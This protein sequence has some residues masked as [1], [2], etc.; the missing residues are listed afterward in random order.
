MIGKTL[1]HYE[2]TELL[3][4]G[5][6]GAVYRARD[7]KLHREVAIK[8]LPPTVADDPERVAR[9]R[10]EARTLASLSDPHVAALYGMEEA[11]E[12]RFLVMELVEGEDLAQRLKRGK[13]SRDETLD[14]AIQIARGVEAAHARGIVHRDL[15][16]ANVMLDEDRRVK[17]LDFG[18]AR[19]V[20]DDPE[21]SVDEHSPTITADLTRAGTLL[22]TA[23]YMS[24]EQA[25]GRAVDHRSDIWAFGVMLYEMLSGERLFHGESVSDTLASVLKVEPEWDAL[26][27]DLP[28]SISRLLRRCLNKD[29]RERLQAIGDARLELQ[30]VGGESV[31][32]P[33]PAK[34][35]R[36][37]WIAAVLAALI[38]GVIGAKTFLPAETASVDVAPQPVVRSSIRLPEGVQLDGAGTPVLAISPDGNTLAF[39]GRDGGFAELYVRNM[40]T[41]VTVKVPDSQ[42]AEGPF[43]SPDSRWIGFGRGSL[44]VADAGTPRI[45]KVSVEGGPAQDLCV[46]RDYFGGVWREDGTIFWIDAQPGGIWRVSSDGGTPREAISEESTSFFWPFLMPGGDIVLAV[47]PAVRRG[48]AAVLVDVE[49]GRATDLGVDAAMAWPLP[50]GHLLLSSFD[51]SELVDPTLRRGES[52]PARGPGLSLLRGA[53]DTRNAGTAVAISSEGT[54]VYSTGSLQFSRRGMTE[55]LRVD[56]E[57]NRTPLDLPPDRYQTFALSPD[58]RRLAV[59]I[60]R[61][62]IWVID[63]ERGTRLLLPPGPTFWQSGPMWSPDGTQ[64]VWSGLG[65]TAVRG[66]INLFTQPAD[67]V[68]PP[69]QLDS[70]TGEFW[71]QSWIPGA[72]VLV[73]NGWWTEIEGEH[74]TISTIALDG[75]REPEALLRIPNA[76]LRSPRVR[77]DGNWLAYT[78]DE[79]G[80]RVAYLSSF[81]DFRRKL[82]V[83]RAETV[84]WSVDG[85]RLFLRTGNV[86]RSV[87]VEDDGSGGLTFGAE[88]TIADIAGF[89][90]LRVDP[91]GRGLLVMR[92]VAGTGR[93]TELEMVRG[94]F[95]EVK[96]ALPGG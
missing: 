19:A 78:S 91:L 73:D 46:V 65:G 42:G 43:F 55:F 79:G 18:L 51:E 39:V 31:A 84:E 22:G 63:L 11:D 28:P 13:L 93:V 92:D 94:W 20:A 68:S 76:Y 82:P 29:R 50:T 58:G 61:R 21:E 88:E 57:G 41:G 26:P 48:G 56:F 27:D 10:R 40:A 67:G 34:S 12:Q 14:I 45:A 96:E 7:R 54:L 72:D 83:S 47:D 81:P 17:I 53:S 1:A 3:G 70:R 33:G 2:I 60:D 85:G 69:R 30:D 49:T 62:G 5:G 15:K 32:A 36:G 77:P 25:R 74:T 23:A 89:R 95:E 38:V 16:P 8:V 59:D 35:H 75:S 44:S 64:L 86:L 4:Q 71:A 90:S 37:A 80:D 52:A 9:F 24:P 66:S 87:S 6:M